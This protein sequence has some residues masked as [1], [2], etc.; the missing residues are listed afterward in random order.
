MIA[1]GRA[2]GMTAGDWA[3]GFAGLAI[4]FLTAAA[5]LA[6]YLLPSLIAWKV[7]HPNGVWIFLLNLLLGWLLVGWIG[8]LIWVLLPQFR[9]L[10]RAGDGGPSAEARLYALEHKKCSQCAE[11]VKR[12][13]L[14]C[15][16]CGNSFAGDGD[17]PAA[18]GPRLVAE[19]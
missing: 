8:A 10:P 3:G 1:P 15:R 6:L 2:R 16:F 19:R 5:G 17:P 4:F 14:V 18:S 7:R 12:E 13:A 11:M 9:G